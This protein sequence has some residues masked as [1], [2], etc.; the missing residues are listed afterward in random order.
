MNCARRGLAPA[1]HSMA[2]AMTIVAGLI[3]LLR[4]APAAA[5]HGKDFLLTATDDMPLRGH[6]YTLLSVDDTIESDS[7]H[8]SIEITLGVLFA[9]TNRFSLEPH[10]HIARDEEGSRYR[11]GA[12]AVEA[13]YAIGYVGR[14]QWRWAGSLEY[15][16]PRDDHDNLEGRLILVRNF[17]R[18]LVAFNLVADRD[19]EAGGRTPLSIIAG[20]LRPLNPTNNVGLEVSAPF[21]LAD[22]V[23]L[24]PGI[25]HVF[26]GPTGRT[27]LKIGVGVFVS[28]DTTAGTFHTAFIQRF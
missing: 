14:S 23:E 13:R 3:L 11:Y 17:T 5:H 1:R 26:G 20:V 15:E 9:V 25:Y 6:L 27:S 24:L 10:V 7:G 19:I 4:P 16:N 21:P 8:R 12:T 22:G 18:S 2:L 28:R